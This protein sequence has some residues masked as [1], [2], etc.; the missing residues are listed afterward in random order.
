MRKGLV[1]SLIVLIGLVIAADRIGLMVAQNEIAKNVAA[2]YSLDQKPKVTIKGFPFLTQALGGDYDEID[3]NVGDLKRDGAT[4]RNTVVALKGVK[5]PVADAL[6]GRT[7]GFTAKT[8]TSTAT[9]DFDTVRKNAPKGMQITPAGSHLKV[10]GR[11]SILGLGTE[12]TATVSVQPAAKG[13]RVVP[14]E[15]DAGGA[16]IPSGLAQQ[17]FSFVVP[18]R[19]LPLGT[20]ISAVEIT[21]D[22]LRVT[23]TADNVKLSNLDIK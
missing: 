23:T 11:I 6:N 5:A 19:D 9:A 18:I 15:V 14:V 1:I 7:S 3:V 22:G 13:I 16:T 12:V 2:Q 10:K 4:L 17:T 8:A 20:R 21:D